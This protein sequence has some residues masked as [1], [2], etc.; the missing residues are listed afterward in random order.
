M[1]NQDSKFSGAECISRVKECTGKIIGRKQEPLDEEVKQKFIDAGQEH[2][3]E[4]VL[5]D[6]FVS[7]AA[8]YNNLNL[9][10]YVQAL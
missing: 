9:H 7:K 1:G 3:F 4:Y 10:V 8:V 6:H 2:I 5:R